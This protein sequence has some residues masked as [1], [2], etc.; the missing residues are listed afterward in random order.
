VNEIPESS[1]TT[2][3]PDVPTTGAD[4]IKDHLTNPDAAMA[5]G[6]AKERGKHR[7][8]TPIAVVLIVVGSVL[9]P[10]AGFTVFIRNQVLNTDRYVSTIAP[11]SKNPAIA[12]VMAN[13]V[14][15]QLFS[16]LDVRSEIKSALPP[17]AGFVAAPLT[18]VLKSQTYNVTNKLILSD[19]FNTV[20]LAMN[21][22][23]H[24][25]LVR[26]LTGSSSGA[27]KADQNGKVTLDLHALAAKAIHQLDKQGIT[28]FDKVPIGKLNLQIVIIQAAGLVK[29]QKL[30]RALNH[31]ALFLPAL[32]LLCFAGAIALSPRR[33]RAAMWSGVGLATSMAV[34]AIMLGLARSYLISASAGHQ[35]TPEAASALFDTMLRYLKTGMRVLFGLGL[36][37]ALIAWLVGPARPVVAL[38]RGTG[39]AYHWVRGGSRDHRGEVGPFGAWVGANR[40]AIQ[41]V[42]A[43]VAV[44]ILVWVTPG[45]VGTLV[46]IVVTGLVV[47][48]VRT[49]SP[50]PASIGP[51]T[52]GVADSTTSRHPGE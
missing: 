3:E 21:R 24:T 1:G 37:V 51:G 31:L 4:D 10:I 29:A 7:V 17:K 48:A 28:I 2:I 19:Q 41:G 47:I 20:W 25:N 32:S 9:A 33:R 50:R 8:R 39:R 46:I 42:V 15:D 5:A 49:I 30:T 26:V 22:A 11:L 13:E 16:H 12:S 34:L 36:V 6:S 44:L 35:L 45:I 14:T 23:V 43:G 27:V 52:D 38:R 40:G 18:N